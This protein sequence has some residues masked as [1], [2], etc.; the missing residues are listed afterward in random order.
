MKGILLFIMTVFV[1]GYSSAESF[2][3][4]LKNKPV[5]QLDLGMFQMDLVLAA[6]V[7]ESKGKWGLTSG[8]SYDRAFTAVEEDSLYV[9]LYGKAPAKNL[10]IKQ[11]SVGISEFNEMLK[12]SE[13]LPTVWPDYDLN[14]FSAYANIKLI[15]SESTNSA[16]K[17]QCVWTVGGEKVYTV[18]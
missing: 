6:K 17:Y 8:I 4:E 12:L 3:E 11:C 10:N 18:N 1:S 7:N 13:I 5:S 9:M 2:V 16:L 14:D 15:I